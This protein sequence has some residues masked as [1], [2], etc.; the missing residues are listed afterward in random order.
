M[1]NP[2]GPCRSGSHLV[3][4]KLLYNDRIQACISHFHC[5]RGTGNQVTSDHDQSATKGLMFL[6]YMQHFGAYICPFNPWTVR[7]LW[8]SFTNA[9]AHPIC[10]SLNGEVVSN[11]RHVLDQC[12]SILFGKSTWNALDVPDKRSD[13][14]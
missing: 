13:L 4:I 6:E 14:N 2:I 10:W 12:T 7:N 11:I 8:H 1:R 3:V 9:S 5:S